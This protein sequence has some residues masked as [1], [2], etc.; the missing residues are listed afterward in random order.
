MVLPY[1]TDLSKQSFAMA[2]AAAIN[3]CDR[4]AATMASYKVVVH[5]MTPPTA[6]PTEEHPRCD[7]YPRRDLTSKG[8]HHS[9]A[10]LPWSELKTDHGND[11]VDRPMASPRTPQQQ[12][13]ESPTLESRLPR[14]PKHPTTERR[15]PQCHSQDP[16]RADLR[17][18]NAADDWPPRRGWRFPYPSR[19]SITVAPRTL[20]SKGAHLPRVTDTNPWKTATARIALETSNSPTERDER[21]RPRINPRDERSN[22][23]SASTA[24][25]KERQQQQ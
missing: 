7:W 16:V 18:A 23:C 1:S 2:T 15:T 24:K 17:D 11:L 14:V 6:T 8:A 13:S 4:D 20:T 22:H 9:L 5:T 3:N 19:H 25:P 10:T 12:R 21:Q